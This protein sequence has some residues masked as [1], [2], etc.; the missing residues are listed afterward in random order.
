MEFENMERTMDKWE[1]LVVRTFGGVVMV[2]N[3]QEVGTLKEGIPIGEMLWEFLQERGEGGWEVVGMAGVR[4]GM[5]M[6]MKRPL[7][8]YEVVNA[9]G[10]VVVEAA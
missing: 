3:G 7:V 9:E 8:D 5:E 4:E 6:V 1:Y 10:E 2:V